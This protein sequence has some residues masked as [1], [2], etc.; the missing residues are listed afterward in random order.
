MYWEEN[1]S[2]TLKE[3]QEVD[4]KVNTR[5]NDAEVQKFDM[6]WNDK[7]NPDLAQPTNKKPYTYKYPYTLQISKYQWSKTFYK[8]SMSPLH[9]LTTRP[10][11]DAWTY[12]QS[13]LDTFTFR[14]WQRLND[15]ETKDSY[16]QKK[17]YFLV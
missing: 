11:A 10:K 2:K 5:M 15:L 7:W 8:E 9:F 12:Q 17:E 14:P 1:V 4:M 16:E 6:E 3:G 13:L